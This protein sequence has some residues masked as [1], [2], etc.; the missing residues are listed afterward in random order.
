M[1][2]VCIIIDFK[3]NQLQQRKCICDIF[4]VAQ[5]IYC[6]L[7]NPKVHKRNNKGKCNVPLIKD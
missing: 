5:C 7:Q 3:C 1:G 2:G 6:K 4:S